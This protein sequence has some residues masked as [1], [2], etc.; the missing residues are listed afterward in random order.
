[1]AYGRDAGQCR[2]AAGGPGIDRD[3]KK[4]YVDNLFSTKGMRRYKIFIWK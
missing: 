2:L 4:K 1:M 3:N